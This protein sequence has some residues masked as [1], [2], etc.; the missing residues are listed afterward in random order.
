MSFSVD[1]VN[2]LLYFAQQ[3]G[4]M[5]GVGAASILLVSYIVSMR[6]G[7]VDPEEDAF[8]HAVTT[9]QTVGLWVIMVSGLAITAMHISGGALDI[10][11]SPAYLFKWLLI[12]FLFSA[13]LFRQRSA[14]PHF[15]WEGIV[16]ANWYALFIIHV[17]APIAMWVDLIVLYVIW[18]VGF[19]LCYAAIV[20]AMHAR[21]ARAPREAQKPKPAPVVQKIVE[22]KVEEPK[23]VSKPIVQSVPKPVPV[24]ARVTPPPPPERPKISAL[25]EHVPAPLPVIEQLRELLVK[26]PIPKAPQKPPMEVPAKAAMSVPHKPPAVPVKPPIKPVEQKITDPDENPGLPAIRVMP[27]TQSDVDK[28]NRASAV[29][30]S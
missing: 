22:K 23:I 10:V 24:A 20:Y 30:F 13:S 26:M 28:Q 29:Q 18:V 5:L 11:L 14:Y 12:G 2:L 25:P 17:V 1:A 8:G 3:L 6:D 15:M 4:V 27:R 7:R 9:I 21:P 16:G 19:V